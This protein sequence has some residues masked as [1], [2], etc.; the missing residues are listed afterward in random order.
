[1][2]KIDIFHEETGL[3][4]RNAMADDLARIIELDESSSGISKPDYWQESFRRFGSLQDGRYFLVA[5]KDNKNEKK[6]QIVGFI[7]GEIRAWEFGS[8][9]GGWVFSLT[10]DPDTRLSGVATVMFNTI[11]QCFRQAGIDKIHTMID[12]DN[13]TVMAFFRSQGMMAASTIPLQLSLSDMDNA[14][15]S[16]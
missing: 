5:E 9:P 13:I 12:R 10:V 15:D 16:S 2:T 6:S 14:G 11:C 3:T 8:Q 4:I 1:M 7:I